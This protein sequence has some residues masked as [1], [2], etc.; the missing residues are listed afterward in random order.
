MTRRVAS[1][2]AP[3]LPSKLVD[4]VAERY[5]DL[6]RMGGLT[7]LSN[8]YGN[9]AISIPVGLLDGLPAGMQVLARRHQDALLFDVALA[10]ERERPW[11]LVAP[12]ARSGHANDAGAATSRR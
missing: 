5:P 8:V 12:I 6:V 3:R 10:V 2:F 7:I 11:P 9:P 1:A 4:A